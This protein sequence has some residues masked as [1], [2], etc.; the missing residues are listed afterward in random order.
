MKEIIED[1]KSTPVY[2]GMVLGGEYFLV[3]TAIGLAVF[4]QTI[5]S[6]AALAAYAALRIKGEGESLREL[7]GLRGVEIVELAWSLV[8]PSPLPVRHTEP[9]VPRG[10]V[11]DDVEDFPEVPVKT[12]AK[13][14]V[15]ADNT[16]DGIYGAQSATKGTDAEPMQATEGNG[17][18]TGI[19]ADPPDEIN[20]PFEELERSDY[21][22][23]RLKTGSDEHTGA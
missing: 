21:G 15:P 1:F 22:N 7:L 8:Q 13:A 5:N 11:L 14:E 4:A 2:A 6:V 20:I 10:T 9:Y 23:H 3:V 18:E 19:L 12:K 17:D 16:S